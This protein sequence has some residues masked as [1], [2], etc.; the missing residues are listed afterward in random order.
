MMEGERWK[1]WYDEMSEADEMEDER[2]TRAVLK[3][4][5][6]EGTDWPWFD[7]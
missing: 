7:Q 3:K 6:T 2:S 4:R 5:S 1:R